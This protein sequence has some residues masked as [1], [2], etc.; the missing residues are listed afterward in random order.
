MHRYSR[1]ALAQSN[2]WSGGVPWRK[3]D[4]EMTLRAMTGGREVWAEK[5]SSV[6][7]HAV[8]ASATLN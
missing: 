8:Q 4:N 1:F 3:W 5:V 2:A 7:R 6:K